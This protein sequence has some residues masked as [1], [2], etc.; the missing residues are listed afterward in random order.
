[1]PVGIVAAGHRESARAGALTLARG[2][3]AVDAAAAAACAASI[4]ENP[5][6]GP[7]AG[8]FLIFRPA[9][10]EPRLV[11]FFVQVPGLGEGGRHL[12]PDMLDS[13]VVP[14]GGADQVF[15]I[16]RASVAVPGFLHGIA[17]AVEH[18]GRLS[19]AE[20]VEPACRLAREGVRLTE[21]IDFL[22]RILGG[23][24]RFSPA[25]EAI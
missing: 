15:H 12:D 1:M 2:G 5:L 6:T 25:S 19:L 18:Y 21:E 23:M 4:A 22:Y 7:G 3:N 9:G 17:H 24:L 16:G 11:D 14:F 13:F 8:G 20:V 10:G